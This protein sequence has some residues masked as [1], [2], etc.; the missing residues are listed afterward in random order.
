[1]TFQ[2]A[3]LRRTQHIKMDNNFCFRNK[4]K[5]IEIEKR[6]KLQFRKF[7]KIRKIFQF[8]MLIE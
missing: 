7:I 6:E 1:M 8:K 5:K 4:R 2:Y 3:C